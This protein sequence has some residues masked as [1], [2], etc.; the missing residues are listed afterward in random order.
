MS[1]LEEKKLNKG[2]D[3]SDLNKPRGEGLA[4]LIPTPPEPEASAEPQTAPDPGPPVSTPNRRSP[5]LPDIA[6]DLEATAPDA[7]TESVPESRPA[8]KQK[9]RTGNDKDFG[10][11]YV[12]ENVRKRFDKYRHDQ[13]LTNAQVVMKA[14]SKLHS[15]LSDVVGAAKYSTAPVDPLFPPD[16]S[17]VKYAGGGSAQIVYATTPEQATV[18]ETIGAEIGFSTRSTWLAPVLNAFLPGRKER[19]GGSV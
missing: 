9:A 4:D 18:L 11:V 6:P 19:A 15:E 8:G 2:P 17:A 3:L 12:T 10:A 1:K 13:R 7:P 16:P 5:D 14:V